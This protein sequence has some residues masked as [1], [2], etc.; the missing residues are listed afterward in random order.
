MF[1]A[2]EKCRA[3][4]KVLIMGDLSGLPADVRSSPSF[5]TF[6]KMLKIYYFRSPPT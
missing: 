5:Q 6:K 1:N 4:D 2:V 3:F